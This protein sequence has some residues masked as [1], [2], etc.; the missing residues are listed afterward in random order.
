MDG[1]IL[2]IT[3]PLNL[4]ISRLTPG[5]LEDRNSPGAFGPVHQAHSKIY[6][7]GSD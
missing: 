6:I 1:L 4:L 3:P 7:I 2:E 5:E